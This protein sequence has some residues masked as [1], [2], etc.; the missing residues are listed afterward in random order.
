MIR[1]IDE[2]GF[3]IC[4]HAYEEYPL[5]EVAVTDNGNYLIRLLI[6]VREKNPREA[7][8]T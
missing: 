3:E 5:N 7:Q 6:T 4:G 2:N 8:T 1:Y